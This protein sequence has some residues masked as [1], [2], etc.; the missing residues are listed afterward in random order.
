MGQSHC[1]AVEIIVGGVYPKP[2]RCFGTPLDEREEEHCA[3]L[4]GN[5]RGPELE[6]HHWQ[7]R[8]LRVSSRRAQVI[9]EFL[10]MLD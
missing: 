3:N 5:Q 8:E 7:C 2:P 6:L 9:D 10:A 1:R 4:V